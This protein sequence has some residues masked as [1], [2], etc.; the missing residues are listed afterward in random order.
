MM[1]IL[2]NITRSREEH[3][4]AD[5]SLYHKKDTRHIVLRSI[6][7]LSICR[8]PVYTALR[9]GFRYRHGFAATAAGI[10]QTH[11]VIIRR[12]AP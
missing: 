7:R 2:L 5:V 1:L 10:N 9:K 12:H 11:I 8:N 3:T 6:N 4:L